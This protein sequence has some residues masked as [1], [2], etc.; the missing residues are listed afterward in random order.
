MKIPRNIKR[1]DVVMVSWWD[2]TGAITSDP[3]TSD[4]APCETP[5]IFYI[6]TEKRGVECLVCA[7]TRHPNWP[8]GEYTGDQTYPTVLVKEVRILEKA[9]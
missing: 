2:F 9:T 4:I 6:V 8:D 3:S 1:G 5:G 7:I